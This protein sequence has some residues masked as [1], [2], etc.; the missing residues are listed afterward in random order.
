MNEHL[1][2]RKTVNYVEGYV[3]VAAVFLLILL[4]VGPWRRRSHNPVVQYGVSG[5]YLLSFA[6]LS[7]TLGLMQGVVKN[8]LYPVWA[9]FIVLLFGGANS[10]S[11]LHLDDNRKW[12][13][14]TL[15]LA[16]Y[17]SYIGWIRG[18]LFFINWGAGKIRAIA[19]QVLSILLG[20]KNAEMISALV[21]ASDARASG[22]QTVDRHMKH[23]EALMS[24]P[25]VYDP[26]SMEG[27]NYL[28]LP[29]DNVNLAIRPREADIQTARDELITLQKIWQHGNGDLLLSSEN[30]AIRHLKDVCLSFALFR[31]AVRRYFG[32]SCPEAGLDKTRDLVLQGLLPRVEEA[33]EDC[34]RAFQVIEVELGFLYDLFHTKYAMIMCYGE[35]LSIGLSLCI[36]FLSIAIGVSAL[37]DLSPKG[38]YWELGLVD[39]E[40]KDII[41]TKL[42]LCAL[43]IF[44]L[45]QIG[46]YCTSDW[47]K[48]SLVC[49]YTTK[50]AWQGN[51]YIGKLFLLIGR[52]SIFLEQHKLFCRWENK[53]GQYSLMDSFSYPNNQFLER[54]SDM[55]PMFREGR[56]KGQSIPVPMEVKIAIA[57]RL[58]AS[59]GQISNGA[60]ALVRHGMPELCWACQTNSDFTLAQVILLWHT[61]TSYCENSESNGTDVQPTEQTSRSKLVATALSKYCAYLVAFA[62]KLVPGSPIETESTLDELVREARGVSKVNPGI[63]EL[64]GDLQE[65][66]SEG[67]VQ[68]MLAKCAAVG[69]QLASMEDQVTRWNL[70]ADFWVELM[71]YI[72]PSDNVAGHIECLAQGG[73]FVTHIWALLMHAGILE[74]PAAASSI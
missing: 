33:A 63:F 22:S 26:H 42:I 68:T 49:K 15:E 73:E 23:Y 37:T 58:K 12:I 17:M 72:A 60:S 64:F 39:T 52:V 1:H 45:L 19:L 43:A 69:I 30:P 20:F 67:R 51:S 70:L 14:P 34:E 8:E 40:K 55:I 66:H 32:Y 7:Y 18:S 16:M 3:A 50:P 29:I 6:L 2:P 44:Q 21:L 48:V 5:V 31:L 11:V 25:N 36:T 13:K 9:T 27:Y 57:R 4:V 59:N 53:I 61:A 71:L 10:V 47:V 35:V 41:I 62:P 46:L 28:V 56:K 65:L 24:A 38:K 74:R 54:H